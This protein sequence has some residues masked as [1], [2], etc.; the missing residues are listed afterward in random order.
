VRCIAISQSH[1][2]FINAYRVGDSVYISLAFGG[3]MVGGVSVA[4]LPLGWWWF[5]VGCGVR[6]V[7]VAVALWGLLIE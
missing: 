6:G 1:N 3:V 7:V 4:L 5:G 2:P